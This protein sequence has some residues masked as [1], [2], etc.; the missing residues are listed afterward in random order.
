MGAG[1]GSL[2]RVAIR[3]QSYVS[4][5]EFRNYSPLY[6]RRVHEYTRYRLPLRFFV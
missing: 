1:T 2:V 5:V 3:L 6:L 4:F